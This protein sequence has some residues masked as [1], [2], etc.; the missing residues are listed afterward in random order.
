[1]SWLLDLAVII[2]FVVY[3]MLGIKRGAVR[4]V[5]E[6]VGFFAALVVAAVFSEQIAGI[7]FQSLVRPSV[8]KA[9]ENMLQNI[10]AGSADPV[11]ALNRQLPSFV[12]QFFDTS[13][14]QEQLETAVNSG[15]ADGAKVLTDLAIGPV[16]T[17]LMQVIAAVVLFIAAMALIRMAAGAMDL[18]AR[19]PVLKQLNK[20]LG[21]VCGAAKGLIIIFLI[22][23]LIYG[24]TPFLPENDVLS[25][26]TIEE[27]RIFGTICEINPLS[28]LAKRG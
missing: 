1:M 9:T 7:V 28:Q 6:F 20:G 23:A 4:T 3:L 25:M 8:L 16:V 27:S 14:L 18:I 17:M 10:L 22:S 5:V 13:A 11:A 12:T 2:V 15:A 26:E 19:L 21:A 24:L